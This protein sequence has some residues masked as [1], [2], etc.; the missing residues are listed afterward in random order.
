MV[1]QAVTNQISWGDLGMQTL[2]VVEEWQLLRENVE[3]APFTKAPPGIIK[4]QERERK[5]RMELAMLS[6]KEEKRALK[7]WN[8]WKKG[9]KMPSFLALSRKD[10]GTLRNL[11][12]KCGKYFEEVNKTSY[13][14]QIPHEVL[15]GL[16]YHESGC[17]AGIKNPDSSATGLTQIIDSTWQ[18]TKKR[19][20]DETGISLKSRKN[21]K[22]SLIGGGWYLNHL[23]H[24]AQQHAGRKLDRQAILDWTLPLQ[25]YY[26]GDGCGPKP[27]CRPEKKKYSRSIISLARNLK[28]PITG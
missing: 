27:G 9:K 22:D 7:A 28:R 4:A 6:L 18:W 15:Y 10:S 8:K 14:F 26:A 17:V 12:L 20:K 5:K 24:L 11:K 21:P 19:L 13:I 25:Y 2:K 16:I 23:F 1:K 3:K